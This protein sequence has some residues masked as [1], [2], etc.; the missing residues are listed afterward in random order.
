MPNTS[1]PVI[2]NGRKSS[3]GNSAVQITATASLCRTGSDAENRMD[4]HT[5]ADIALSTRARIDLD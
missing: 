5:N 3:I 2:A 4:T 1:T